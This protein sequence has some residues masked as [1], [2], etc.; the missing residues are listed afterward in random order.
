MPEVA[1]GPIVEGAYDTPA[2]EALV[3]R[4]LHPGRVRLVRSIEA[5][6]KPGLIKRLTGY[7]KALGFADAGHPV[8]LAIVVCDANAHRPGEVERKI[9]DRTRSVSYRFQQGILVHAVRRETQTR[10]LADPPGIGRVAGR[11]PPPEVHGLSE[12]VQDAKAR[13]R[14]DLDAVNVPYTPGIC[15]EIARALDLDRPRG[16]RPGFCRFEAKIRGE[17]GPQSGTTR[18]TRAP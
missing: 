18:R 1:L 3:S 12:D 4:I 14:R 2:L 8:A 10:L 6:G 9:W 13:L 15:G 5:R 11:R 7:L 16:R 17:P